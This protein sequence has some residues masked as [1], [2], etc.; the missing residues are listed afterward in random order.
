MTFVKGMN[1]CYNIGKPR[2][3][4]W[5]KEKFLSLN[6]CVMRNQ[7]FKVELDAK[8]MAQSFS[9]KQYNASYSHS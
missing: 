4:G 6:N 3:E 5:L 8:R 7:Y 2:D 1:Y 9:K